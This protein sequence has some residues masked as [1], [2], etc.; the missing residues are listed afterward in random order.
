[1]FIGKKLNVPG[2]RDLS[3]AALI[4]LKAISEFPDGGYG[5][6]LMLTLTKK[7][8]W[9]VKS[10]TVYPILKR[11]LEKKYVRQLEGESRKK[12]Y[13]ITP[14]GH[15]LLK[16]LETE[17]SIIDA[18]TSPDG[19]TVDVVIEKLREHCDA[20]ASMARN[21]EEIDLVRQEIHR[22]RNQIGKIMDLVDEHL[23]KLK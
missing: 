2:Q 21:P 7:Y 5:Y 18:R 4:V 11:L 3:Y 6:N 16:S 8:D 9:A 10:G 20:I 23:Q 19:W 14:L 1:L 22:I 13:R 15:E 17:L 12:M